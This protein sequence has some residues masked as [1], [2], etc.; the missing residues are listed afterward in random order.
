MGIPP[1]HLFLDYDTMR[2]VDFST[3]EDSEIHK[4]QN[5]PRNTKKMDWDDKAEIMNILGINK[6]FDNLY[7]CMEYINRINS[8]NAPLKKKILDKFKILQEFY[9]DFA[10]CINETASNFSIFF[11]N[12]EEGFDIPR[13]VIKKCYEKSDEKRK[14]VLFFYFDTGKEGEMFFY[15]DKTLGKAVQVSREEFENRF[16]CYDTDLQKNNG[17]NLWDK[18]P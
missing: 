7:S 5:P 15:A 16:A 6:D 17:V 2:E 3:E 8:Q 11:F 10:E 1:E 13:T 9:P 14:A 12:N 18:K 4:T